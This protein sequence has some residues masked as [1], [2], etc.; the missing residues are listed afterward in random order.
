[1]IP[2]AVFRHFPGDVE[3]PVRGHL[4]NRKLSKY[5]NRETAAL[6][7]CAA[8]LLAGREI[9]AVTPFAYAMGQVEHE[10][11]GLQ[12]LGDGS[13]GSD[14]R[15]CHDA[16]IATGIANVS[17]LTQFKVLYNMPLCFVSIEH[18]LTGENAILYGTATS[19]VRSQVECL[20]PAGRVLLGA[21]HIHHDG[22]VDVGIALLE[23]DASLIPWETDVDVLSLL[24]T[25][26]GA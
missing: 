22:S 6:V 8:I 4:R 13:R 15:F 5:F 21:G 25:W 3:I 10:D 20:E 19:D 17:P 14:D 9:P 26:A 23:G 2:A 24:K 18:G 16:F 7:T 1:M 11:Y 12:T